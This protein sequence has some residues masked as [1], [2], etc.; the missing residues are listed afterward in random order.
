MEQW[1]AGRDS[2]HVFDHEIDD[3]REGFFGRSCDVRQREYARIEVERIGW[4]RG[5]FPVDIEADAA[6]AIAGECSHQRF[7]IDHA[8]PCDVDQERAGP[9][10]RERLHPDEAARARIEWTMNA[11]RV[12]CGEE[13]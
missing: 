11:D 7:A 1:L 3:A 6:E 12:A 10:R 13:P 9:H 8:A 4:I 5:L 2:A